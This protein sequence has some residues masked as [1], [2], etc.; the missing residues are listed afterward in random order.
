MFVQ[1]VNE[2]QG[3][4]KC[5]EIGKLHYVSK[6]KLLIAGIIEGLK[7]GHFC[8]DLAVA[9]LQVWEIGSALEQKA[10]EQALDN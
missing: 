6:T 1:L 2:A 3:R 5:L 9:Y 7:G 4:L 10:I 8:S